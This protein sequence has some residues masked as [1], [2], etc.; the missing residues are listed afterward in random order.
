MPYYYDFNSSI[1]FSL[2]WKSLQYKNEYKINSS[3]FSLYQ[4]LSDEVALIALNLGQGLNHNLCEALARVHGFIFCPYGYA[5][6]N[7]IK[8]YLSINNIDVDLDKIKAIILKEKIK[9]VRVAPPEE[10]FEYVEELF[11]DNAT[12]KEVKLVQECYRIIKTL[13][14]HRN[15]STS[16]YFD[17]TSSAL[18]ELKEK[19]L[20]LGDIATVDLAKYIPFDMGGFTCEL[21]KADKE[22]FLKEFTDNIEHYNKKYPEKSV[23]QRIKLAISY[24]LIF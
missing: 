2:E 1:R 7:A 23:E 24:T 4:L 13:Q 12:K 8:E 6:W 21:E 22:E 20:K 3:E 14:P 5:G 11:T 17:L 16:E 10:F 15:I 9:S 18:K 19:S